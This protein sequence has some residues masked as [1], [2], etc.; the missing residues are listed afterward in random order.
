MRCAQYLLRIEKLNDPL[1]KNLTEK[2]KYHAINEKAYIT[3]GSLQ[4]LVKN[5]TMTIFE[6]TD[7]IFRFSQLA[8]DKNIETRSLKAM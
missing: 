8:Y 1:L 2:E 7:E 6:Y 5:S 4:G 3:K